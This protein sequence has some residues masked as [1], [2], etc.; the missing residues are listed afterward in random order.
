MKKALLLLVVIIFVSVSSIR[1]QNDVICDTKW[2]STQPEILTYQSRSSQGDGLYQVSL[3]RGKDCIEAYTN[4]ITTGFTKSV[5]GTMTEA[6][7]PLR[8]TSRII[9]AGQVL[10]DTECSYQDSKVNISTLMRPYNQI[11]KESLSSDH[12]VIDHSQISFILRTLSLGMGTQYQ[13][14]SLDPRNNMLV[15]LTIKVTGEETIHDID[16]FIVEMQSFEGNSLNWVE[17]VVP[18]R[19]IR[20]TQSETER[21]TE[22]IL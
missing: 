5:H 19:I 14:D 18:H 2:I 3:Y 8:S 12:L 17:K 16:C 4:I 21:V 1:A 9:V 11:M 15:P 22:L 10:F 7:S 13:L 6:M 20:V